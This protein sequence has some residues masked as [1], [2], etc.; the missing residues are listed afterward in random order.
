MGEQGEKVFLTGAGEHRRQAGE[1]VAVVH[2]GIEVMTLARR[3]QA[4][5]DRRRAATAVASTKEPVLASERDA[6]YRVFALVVVYVQPA[7]FCV[8]AQRGPAETA[9]SDCLQTPKNPS[10]TTKP[11]PCRRGSKSVTKGVV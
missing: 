9:C 1:N 4:E 7:R 3:Q 6:S 8:P 11:C 10:G 5:M 2:A